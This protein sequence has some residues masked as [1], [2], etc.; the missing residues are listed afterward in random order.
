MMKMGRMKMNYK[1]IG[2]GGEQT[3]EINNEEGD[4]ENVI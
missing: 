4:N 3:L 1:T 2:K